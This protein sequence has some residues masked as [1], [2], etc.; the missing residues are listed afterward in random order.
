MNKP[1]AIPYIRFSS[2]I[3]GNG[4]SVAR[5]QD[6]INKWLK[7][8]PDVLLSDLQFKDLGKSGYSG[9]HLKHDLGKL[10]FA[11]K[12]GHIKA[13][14]FILIEAMD[15]LGRLPELE[16]ISIIQ[17]IISAGIKIVT[18]Q[19]NTE[20]STD[21]IA[22]NSGLLY[23]L[24]GK[25]QGAHQYSKSL[26]DR[27]SKAWEDKKRK[28]IEGL[29]VKRK[30]PWWITWDDLTKRYDKVTDDDKYILNSVYNLYLGGFG[31][32]R[33]LNRLREKYPEK[34]GT[35]DPASVKR[36]L[37]NKT[38]I[39]YWGD[40]PNVYP[41]AIPESLFY[42]AQAELKNRGAGKSQTPRS[43]RFL[44]GLVKCGCCGGNYAI[45]SNPHSK[46]AML[47]SQSNKRKD[48]CNNKK[49]IPYQ[50]LDWVRS[51]TYLDALARI[52]TRSQKTD[53]DEKLIVIDGELDSLKSQRDNLLELGSKVGFNDSLTNKYT[54]LEQQIDKLE[55]SR[56]G[57]IQT[58]TEP[59]DIDSSM[60]PELE[61]DLFE[62]V[63][64]FGQLLQKVG[65]KIVV[66]GRKIECE[67]TVFEYLKWSRT[68][69]TY[70]I[71][72]NGV[73]FVELSV[74]RDVTDEEIKDIQ[75][76][77]TNSFL[78]TEDNVCDF[79]L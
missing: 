48:K 79:T 55:N 7:S 43:G 19:D 2:L 10:L 42:A 77:E 62:D 33:I 44:C 63:E 76:T 71:L 65:Y 45:R 57:I 68:N 30:T 58:V 54:I 36:W 28:A 13:G 23:V 69:D 51:Q 49:T 14:D 29:G 72:V 56:V 11:V 38:A 47:C 24:V 3:Q 41:P 16:M 50:V 70:H 53:I 35:T 39:G 74:I 66:R 25:V 34:F 37:K 4:S 15:R 21:S 73:D 12:S 27:L 52:A 75:E 40:I 59:K 6:Y 61:N 31:E 9:K 78:I 26:S 32:R 67:G 46:D 17:Q 64:A 1:K 8:N 20:Y 5:Q 22:A 18:L 60:L